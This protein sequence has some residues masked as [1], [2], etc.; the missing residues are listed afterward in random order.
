MRN[1][2]VERRRATLERRDDGDDASFRVLGGAFDGERD[3]FHALTATTSRADGVEEIFVTTHDVATGAVRVDRG[4][5]PVCETR[6]K[7]VCVGAACCYEPAQFATALASGEFIAAETGRDGGGDARDEDDACDVVGEI[8]QGVVAFAWCPDG[9][10]CAALTRDARVVVMTKDFYP[11]S[12]SRD[13]A[14]ADADETSTPTLTNG[15]ISWRGDGRYFA[16]SSTNARTG[17]T[18]IKVWSREGV[19]VESACETRTATSG[20][21]ATLASRGRAPPPLAWQPRGALI[22]AAG[23][24]DGDENDCVVFYERNGLRRGEFRLPRTGG[25]GGVEITSLAWSADSA[26]LSV[27]VRY[28]G[29]NGDA[30]VQIWTRSNMHWYMKHET[31]YDASEGDARAEWDAERGDVLR[32]YTEKGT[33]ERFDLYWE[34]TTSDRG[35]CAVIDGDVV[36]LTP[37]RR[38]PVPPPMCAAKAVFSAPVVAVAFQPSYAA[39]RGERVVAL[40]SNGA[41]ESVECAHGADWERAADEFADSER[42]ATWWRWTENE[43]PSTP[44]FCVGGDRGTTTTVEFLA[45]IRDTHVVYA[46]RRADDA[47]ACELTIAPFDA[48]DEKSGTTIRVAPAVGALTSANG[49]VFAVTRRAPSETYVVDVSDTASG[50]GEPFAEARLAESGVPTADAGDEL[51]KIVDAKGL[52]VGE[53]YVDAFGGAPGSGALVTLDARGMLRIGAFVVASGV[54][55]FAT[56]VSSADGCAVTS[57]DESEAVAVS[58]RNPL[59]WTPDATPSTRVAYVTKDHRLFVAEVDDALADTHRRGRDDGGARTGGTADDAHIGNWLIERSAADG[60]RMGELAFSDLH[61][62]M[63]R[64]MRPEAAK[65]AAD[66]GTRQVEDG[67]RVVA[68]VPG[69]TNVVLQ[70][71]RGNLEIVSPKALVLP[72]VACALRAKRYA[73]AYTLASKQRVD[74]NLIVDYGWPNFLSDADAFVADVRSADA[75]M[76]LLEALDDGDVTAPGAAYAE[77]ARLYPPPPRDAKEEG[78]DDDDGSNATTKMDRKDKVQTVCAAVRRAIEKIGASGDRWELAALTS[79]ASG[80]NPDLGSALRRV[81]AAREKELDV[82]SSDDIAAS[83]TCGGGVDAAA[84]LKH[85]LFLV[86]GKTLYSAALGTYDL[87]LAYLVAQHAQMDPGEYVAELQNLQNMREHERRAEIAR[88][89]GKYE[90][91]IVEYMLDADVDRAAAVAAERKLFPHALAEAARLRLPDVRRALLIKHAENLSESMRAEDAAVAR[92]AAGDVAGALDEYRA[93]T[94]WQQAL[95]LAGR[96]GLSSNERRAIAEEL[97][98]SIS[99]SDPLAAGRV[100]ARHL[101]DIDRAVD[102][103][104]AARAWREASETAY[105]HDRGDLM[106]TTIAPACAG[107]AEEYFESFKESKARAEKYAARL[108]ELRAHRARIAAA[109]S[110]GGAD[111]SELGGRPRAGFGAPVGDEDAMSEAP[112]L[113]SDMSAYTDRTSATTTASAT[114]AA[115]TVGG[116]K[117]KKRKD[118][119]KNNKRSGLR[120]GSPTEE[121]DLALHVAGLEPSRRTLEEIGELLELMTLLGHE[122]DARSLQRVVGESVDA[123]ALAKTDAETTLKELVRRAEANG[124]PTAEFEL[125]RPAAPEWKWSLLRA[126]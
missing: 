9:E 78:K 103:F 70:M 14:D 68:C 48:A 13:D 27:A 120:A 55:S 4:R 72:A 97:C 121:R 20:T 53:R 104:A 19:T 23:R 40:C 88:R 18:T 16:C 83:G 49:A 63:R 37:M 51:F 113:A 42:A 1:L 66:A 52:D 5:A 59:S 67:A 56:H 87:S 110:L 123:H 12:E 30:A 32:A 119:K 25:G 76:E 10:V 31:R 71:P 112:S 89:L 41:I 58:A 26:A 102:F 65:F 81:A 94:S 106:E 93:G 122:D 117:A 61:T 109:T 77:L 6:E 92:L 85:L 124:E 91:A 108:R 57:A 82:A 60:A 75:V 90:D 36:M 35:T 62:R 34:T 84:A 45:W 50:G 69:S 64:A 54:T 116:R 86:G 101:R 15:T 22:A 126:P 73:D 7:S 100:A 114:S 44:K 33:I 29:E 46:S 115:S 105:S 3:A 80:E 28:G 125:S 79:Y 98:E 99:L 47:D 17:E 24:L 8:P 96:L 74:L 111:W 11:L 21:P 118:K 2:R 95:A 107:A 39:N 43:I 38:T